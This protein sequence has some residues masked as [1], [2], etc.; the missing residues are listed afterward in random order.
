MSNM[1]AMSM[2]S[3]MWKVRKAVLLLLLLEW[4]QPRGDAADAAAGALVLLR[5]RQAC[6]T[7]RAV[8]CK[9]LGVRTWRMGLMMWLGC[10]NSKLAG[11]CS[12]SL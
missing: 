12:R 4:L 10:G 6:I 7:C 9:T 5:G 8:R 1:L 3:E 11:N 2:A